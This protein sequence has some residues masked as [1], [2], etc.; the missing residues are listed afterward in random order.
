M[1]EL[2]KKYQD[3]L[4]YLIFGVL[5][6]LVNL[7]T[8][9]VLVYFH[10]NVQIANVTAWILSVLFAYLTNRKWVFHSK[11]TTPKAIGREALSFTGARFATLL[12][13]I[14]II[15]FGVQ[16]LH[17]NPFIWKLID[18]VVVVILNYILSKLVVFKDNDT[19]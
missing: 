2:F 16:F 13:D 9:Y 4:M 3:V 10:V 19:H 15:W 5:T 11:A 18:N 7:V 17:Q 12:V 14:M 8:F 6:T 1:T